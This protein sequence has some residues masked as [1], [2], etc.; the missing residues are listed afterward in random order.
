MSRITT[1]VR[2]LTLS[3]AAFGEVGDCFESVVQISWVNVLI[4]VSWRQLDV[5]RKT[6][7]KAQS[8][9]QGLQQ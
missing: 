3:A 6:L 1:T 2:M 4:L 7:S 8:R 9:I 5:T